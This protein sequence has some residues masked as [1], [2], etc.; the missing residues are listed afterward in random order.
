MESHQLAQASSSS[1]TAPA[2][3][4]NGEPGAQRLQL[5]WYGIDY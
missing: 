2:C 5:P 4:A 1:D 3:D